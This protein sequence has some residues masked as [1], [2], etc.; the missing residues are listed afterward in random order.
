MA[1]VDRRHCGGN[2]FCVVMAVA[3]E[4][5]LSRLYAFGAFIL[6]MALAALRLIGIGKKLE[7]GKQDEQYIETRKKTD[8]ADVGH[9]DV[10]DDTAW[11]RDRQ[12]KRNL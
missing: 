3:G 6:A 11:L 1:V 4:K 7:Q 10:A 9:G 2:G 5:A 8:K 12:S